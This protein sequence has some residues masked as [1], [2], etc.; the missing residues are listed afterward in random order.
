MGTDL[1]VL[2]GAGVWEV[3]FGLGLW[4]CATELHGEKRVTQSGILRREGS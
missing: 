3:G 1:E 2:V 4:F